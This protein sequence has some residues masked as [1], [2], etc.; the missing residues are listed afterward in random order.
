MSLKECIFD[1]NSERKLYTHLDS[2]WKNQFDIYP[3]LPFTKVF[4]IDS[5]NVDSYEKSFLYKTNIDYTVCDNNGKPKMCI[6]F[7]G[8]SG[9]YSRG[10]H[11]IQIKGDTDRKWKLELKLRIA[12]EH[13][14]PFYVVSFPEK[15]FLS[16]RIHLTVLDGIIGQTIAY[17]QVPK[18]L[19]EAVESQR[20]LLESLPDDERHKFFQEMITSVEVEEE[21]RWDPI[22]QAWAHASQTLRE[23]GIEV[24]PV[25]QPFLPSGQTDWRKCEVKCSTSKGEV[26]ALVWVRNF[27][28]TKAIPILIAENIAR[29]LAYHKVAKLY[30]IDL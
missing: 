15:E 25:P 26:S 6:E 17:L 5:L 22:T 21:F 18:A 9:G 30:G 16:E 2:I 28:G 4:D 23:K 19:G 10:G 11:Y 12:M 7:D 14:F 24:W 13:G 29:L 1:S 20:E 8:M 27:K 3:N